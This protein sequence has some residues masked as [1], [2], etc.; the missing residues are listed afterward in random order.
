MMSKA[1]EMHIHFKRNDG[2]WPKIE[3][4]MLATTIDDE[5]QFC[6]FAKTFLENAQKVN[7]DIYTAMTVVC[8]KYSLDMA[9]GEIRTSGKAIG[10]GLD[11]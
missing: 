9:S 8:G 11:L 4:Y 1:D 6:S 10:R 7:K 5:G 3:V 2:C